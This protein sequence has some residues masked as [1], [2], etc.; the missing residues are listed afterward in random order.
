MPRR[1][2]IRSCLQ[3]LG[4]LVC[5]LILSMAALAAATTV[6][7]TK[8]VP[9]ESLSAT[10]DVTDVSEAQVGTQYTL[11][12]Y[13]GGQLTLRN[14]QGAEFRL[15]A[16]ATDY[17]PPAPA[18]ASVTGKATSA[19]TTSTSSTS[20]APAPAA[21]PQATVQITPAPG[22][23]VAA[24]GSFPT[25]K[26]TVAQV[27]TAMGKPFFTDQPLWQETALMVAQRLGLGLEGRTDWEASYRH[28]FSGQ[29]NDPKAVI[30]GNGAYC[31]AIYADAQDHPTSILIAFAND[32][33]FHGIGQ[34]AATL[35]GLSNSLYNSPSGDL[36]ALKQEYTNK[37]VEMQTTFE[38]VREAEQKSLT[39]HLTSLFGAPSQTSF[40]SDVDT[41]ENALR[42]D[43]N[44]AS[45]LL[46][47]EPRKYDL[48]RIVPTELADSTGRAPRVARDDI[49]HKLS[50]AV[51]HR[52][53]GD[54]I[55][56]QIPM[57]NQGQKGYC[58]PATWERVLRYTGVPGDM[59][60]LSRIGNAGFGGG[61]NGLT[62]ADE[63]NKTLYDYGRHVEVLHPSH[64]DYIAIRHYIDDGIPIFW[65]V[66]PN[67]YDGATQRYSLCD[68]DK[69]FDTWKKLLAQA[70]ATPETGPLPEDQGHQVLIIGYNP[71]TKEIAWT[72]PWGRDFRERWMTQEEA[73]RCSLGQYYIISW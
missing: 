12:S 56:T 27:N 58:V 6:T 72:D 55:I 10:G 46:T 23:S 13:A 19:A 59:Y 47:C 41:K 42:W 67:G 35:Q 38:P 32:G 2:A 52:D 20:P 22:P 37:F 4:V 25:G 43:W 16:T 66:N 54:V 39:D 14:T 53:N 44:G 57:A 11:V 8:Q 21:A 36:S 71:D 17:T 26:I 50:G 68:R 64:L 30:L 34:V 29:P 48:L 70:R 28:Y 49:G 62:V 9:I 5:G 15:A 33:D 61:E 73:Q 69:D 24:T 45:F 60:T 18:A 3:R 31:V 63:L 40:G 51:V 1:P 7:V 65:S